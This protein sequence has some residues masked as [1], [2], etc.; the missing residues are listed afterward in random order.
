MADVPV[1][2]GDLVLARDGG[3]LV[4]GRV[5]GLAA[6]GS[7]VV[8][9]LDRPGRQRLVALAD[10][11]DHWAHSGRPADQAPVGQLKLDV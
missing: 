1:H 11:L 3:R 7:L 5:R 2:R 8:E 6:T 9:A 10:V 4:H